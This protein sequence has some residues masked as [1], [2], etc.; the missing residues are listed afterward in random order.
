MAQWLKALTAL[1]EEQGSIL[2]SRKSDG[3]L[4]P[5]QALYAHCAH[6]HTHAG[7]MSIQ[8]KTENFQK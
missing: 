8:L 6:T 7:Q 5:P 4:W 1:P 3:Q 2:S